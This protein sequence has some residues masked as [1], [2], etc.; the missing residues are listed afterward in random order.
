MINQ[1]N[2][3]NYNI[4]RNQVLFINN[5]LRSLGLKTSHNGYKFIV[6]AILIKLDEKD[7]F[8]KFELIYEKISIAINKAKSPKQ[9]EDSI[10]YAITHRNEQ[11]SKNGFEKVFGYPYDEEIFS[12]KEFI[13]E[14]V[15]LLKIDNFY[16]K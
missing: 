7:D 16:V 2:V 14:L 13:E 4:I 1:S 10:Y 9:I 11:I 15:N 5:K 12:N 3:E 6:K 8:S